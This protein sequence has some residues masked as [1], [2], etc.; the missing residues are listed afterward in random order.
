MKI[1]DKVTFLSEV[2]GGIVSGFQGKNIVL[3]EDSDGFEIPMRVSDV[4]V[5]ESESY[6][7]PNPY[8]KSNKSYKNNHAAEDEAEKEQEPADLPVT[9]RAEPEERKGGEKLYAYLAF[10]P[11]DVK[12][13]DNNRY[14]MFFINDSNYYMQFV[15][16]T[17]ENSVCH[18]RNTAL[19]EPN[20]KM[21]LGEIG[22]EDLNGLERVLMQLI[23]YKENKPYM[24]R[25]VVD[26]ELRIDGRKFYK[27]TSFTEND[28]FE[29]D[30]MLV[31][32]VEDDRVS[33]K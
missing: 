13:M 30:A 3:V 14:Q 1:G 25:P 2:G 6:D 16:A 26:V 27:I 17:R 21:L 15:L 10:V 9:F 8:A 24:R 28:F 29:E 23:A 4:V 18:M 11:M 22:R 32:V 31:P 12:D 19:V 5:V 7:K 33:E 20:T